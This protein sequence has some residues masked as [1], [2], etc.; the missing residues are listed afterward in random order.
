MKIV[1]ENRTLKSLLVENTKGPDETNIRNEL[2]NFADILLQNPYSKLKAFDFA[3]YL[4]EQNSLQPSVP[5]QL[6]LDLAE[7]QRTKRIY[8]FHLH[9]FDTA[10]G[11]AMLN[12]HDYVL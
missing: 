2:I 7:L 4:K 11:K 1:R 9:C 3:C 12:A 10:S 6:W 8:H 5:L